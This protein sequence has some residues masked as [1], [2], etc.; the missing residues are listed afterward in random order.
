MLID[1]ILFINKGYFFL[2][3]THI[4]N[5]LQIVMETRFR[6]FYLVDG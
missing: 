6:F 2:E 5:I 3:D 1:N 4:C